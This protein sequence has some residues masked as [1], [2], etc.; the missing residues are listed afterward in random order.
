MHSYGVDDVLHRPLT[1]V[2]AI[3]RKL[4]LDLLVNAAGD[5]DA[6]RLC[7]PLQARRNIHAVADQKLLATDANHVAIQGYDTVA[8]FTDHKAIKG[9]SAYELVWDDAKWQFAS[10][11]HRDMFTSNP[12]HYMPQ[13]GGF[14]AGAMWGA[15]G[16]SGPGGVGHC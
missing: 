16:A 11:P 1:E 2:V 4:I 10:A 7:Q 6:V 8:Y 15:S 5:A 3:K 13:F 9:S 12:D 14:C